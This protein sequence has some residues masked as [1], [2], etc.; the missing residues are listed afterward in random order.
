MSDKNLKDIEKA[1]GIAIS[2]VKDAK[3]LEV[4]A[5]PSGSYSVDYALG[6]GGYPR[7]RIIEMFGQPSGGKTTLALLAIAEAQKAGG[8]AAFIDAEHAFN[9]QWASKLGVDVPNLV[10]AQPDSGEQALE[11]VKALAQTNEYDMIVVDSTAALVPK[12]MFEA[13]FADH[14]IALQA[15]MMSKALPVLVPI[16]GKSKSVVIFINQTRT[17][18]MKMFGDPTETPGG[19]ALKFYSSI[20]INVNKKGGTDIKDGD[21]VAGHNVRIK[22]VKNKVAPPFKEAEFTLRYLSGVD[23]AE[24]LVNLAIEKQ[25]IE[26]QGPMY[27]YQDQKWKGQD[28]VIEAVRVDEVFKTTLL[29]SIKDNKTTVKQEEPNDEESK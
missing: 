2:R 27:T 6:V 28:A 18:P 24:E 15:R 23:H 9:P 25:I 8:Q 22:V 7:G 1:L 29:A 17:N 11:L 26:R 5:I 14:K 13:D 21:G 12:E 3:S 10:F 19:A 20:R 16:V 4:D